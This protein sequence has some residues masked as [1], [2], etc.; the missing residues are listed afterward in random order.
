MLRYKFDF[1]YLSIMT[2]WQ[3]ASVTKYIPKDIKAILQSWSEFSY[4]N[5]TCK[6][7]SRVYNI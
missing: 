7:R 2:G 3:K 4:N 6:L 5:Y 1:S